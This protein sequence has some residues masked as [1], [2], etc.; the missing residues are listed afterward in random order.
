LDSASEHPTLGTEDPQRSHE[1]RV[2]AVRALVLYPLNALVE[3]QLARLRDGLD[4]PGA[5]AWLQAHRAGN[6]FYF[7]RYTGRTPVSGNR[8]AAAT[9]R[10]RDELTDAARDAQLVAGTPAARFFAT[11]DG[12]EMW[13]RWDMQDSP[14]DILITN[15]SMLNIM[16]MR[17]VKPPSSVKHGSGCG[18]TRRTYFIWWWTN[19][20]RTEALGTEVAYLVRLLLDRLGLAPNSNQLRII[21]SSAS[22]ASGA[23]GLDYLESFF[24]RDRNRFRIVGGSSQPLNAAALAAVQAHVPALRQ[25]RNDLRASPSLTQP[26]AAAFHN[27]TG[28]TPAAPGAAAEAMLDAALGHVMASDALRAA[29]A[30]GPANS[31]HLEPRLRATC[32]AM[33]PGLQAGTESRLSKA[34]SQ[35]LL[36]HAVQ[37][38]RRLC[39]F[40]RTSFFATCKVSGFARIRVARRL[41]GGRHRYRLACFTMCQPLLAGAA[42]ASLSCS[43]A[44]RV[45][46]S[47]L[48]AIAATQASIRTSG[49]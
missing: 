47:C 25:L 7:G 20:T 19:C 44:R 5:R 22:I 33:F 8:S 26:T 4:G 30:T 16:L 1:N 38:V 11:M 48:A 3:D 42:R 14:P 9:A 40:G 2:A 17:G 32:A 49:I 27:A 36:R 45:A 28:A 29:C 18:K 6:R 31:P 23:T 41:R 46:R 15:Y 13:S 21:A 43:I 10:L 24:G 39:P 12:G 34:F 35:A 37:A